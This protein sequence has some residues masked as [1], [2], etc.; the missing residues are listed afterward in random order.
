[1]V[2]HVCN[3]SHTG[4]VGKRTGLGAGGQPGQKDSGFLYQNQKKKRKKKGWGLAQVAEFLLS[5]RPGLG[6]NLQCC[7]THQNKTRKKEADME[8]S[9]DN[10]GGG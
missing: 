10:T 9:P 4:D 7:K 2:V 6:F 1:M 3:P 8:G 5:M